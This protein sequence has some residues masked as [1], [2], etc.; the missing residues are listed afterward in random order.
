M[1]GR[2]VGGEDRVGG[3]LVGSGRGGRWDWLGVGGLLT[4]FAGGSFG[5][6]CGV[7]GVE[8]GMKLWDHPGDVDFVVLARVCSGWGGAAGYVVLGQST[9]G[10]G[11][12][13]G[14]SFG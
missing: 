8:L 10:G 3:R 9:V 4:V 2:L 1:G 13:G 12:P 6:V 7:E 5:A 14:E 11:G